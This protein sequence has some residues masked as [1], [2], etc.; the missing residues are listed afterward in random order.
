VFWDSFA[1]AKLLVRLRRFP[2]GSSEPLV[3]RRSKHS[4]YT[5]TYRHLC[6]KARSQLAYSS[7]A[8]SSRDRLPSAG[9]LRESEA[10]CW[11]CLLILRQSVLEFGLGSGTSNWS[12]VLILGSIRCGPSSLLQ[13]AIGVHLGTKYPLQTPASCPPTTGVVHAILP[14]T[15]CGAVCTR[16]RQ[17]YCTRVVMCIS[18]LDRQKGDLQLCPTVVGPP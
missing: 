10:C 16:A 14:S 11:T 3:V 6:S 18:D 15:E 17:P 1:D 4:N 2:F 12:T 9:N 5:C 7:P 13:A 8:M